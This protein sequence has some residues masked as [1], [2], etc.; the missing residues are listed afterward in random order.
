MSE[1]DGMSVAELEAVLDRKRAHLQTL[2]DRREAL[3]AELAEV[4]GELASLGGS[5]PRRRGRPA[6]STNKAKKTGGL[7]GKRPKNKLTMK[8]SIIKALESS[9]NGLTLRELAVVVKKSGYKSDSSNFENVVYQCL[10]NNKA[11]FPKDGDGK[12][13]VAK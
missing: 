13:S 7:R 11:M 4:E 1:L 3:Q 2:A 10:H 5:A 9:K 12:Y 8:K 6:G